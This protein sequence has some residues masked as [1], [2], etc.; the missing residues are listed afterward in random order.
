MGLK[1]PERFGGKGIPY[2]VVSV[3]SRVSQSRSE[4]IVI[5]DDAGRIT[6]ARRVRNSVDKHSRGVL[7]AALDWMT[8]DIAR[9]ELE[10]HEVRRQEDSR[11]RYL[12][13][14]ESPSHSS[15]PP[16]EVDWLKKD[17]DPA[18]IWFVTTSTEQAAQAEDLGL[19]VACVK[20]SRALLGKV[21]DEI[22][23]RV[24]HDPFVSAGRGFA[25]PESPSKGNTSSA[26]YY[27]GYTGVEELRSDLA[28]GLCK[29][30]AGGVGL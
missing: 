16:P 17:I 15:E 3:T 29:F 24:Q 14:L 23:R 8:T 7:A 25:L 9:S 12:D 28:D 11:N 6:G 30:D 22:D 5:R 26:F 2:A 27:P 21:W 4:Q 13:S 18:E 20:R 1:G 19:T 10:A